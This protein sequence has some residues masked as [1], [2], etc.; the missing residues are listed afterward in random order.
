MANQTSIDRR[1][2]YSYYIWLH[3]RQGEGKLFLD[4]KEY[5]LNTKNGVL[6]Y[7]GVV[8]RYYA[9]QEPWTTHWV[10]FQGFAVKSL[11]QLMG[12]RQSAVFELT[13]VQMLERNLQELFACTMSDVPDLDLKSSGRLYN[14]LVEFPQCVRNEKKDLGE[15]RLEPLFLYLEENYFFALSNPADAGDSDGDGNKELMVKFDRQQV[16]SAL[17]GLQG[18]IEFSIAGGLQDGRSFMGSGSF[19]MKSECG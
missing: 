9:I 15:N 17:N 3:T 12:F 5:V 6:I 13:N 7:P 19:N 8:H 18:S 16:V 1:D 14:F 4:D 2:G 10:S 11:L